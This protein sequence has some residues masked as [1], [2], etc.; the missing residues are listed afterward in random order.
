MTRI[1]YPISL[2]KNPEFQTENRCLLQSRPGGPVHPVLARDRLQRDQRGRRPKLQLRGGVHRGHA[3]ALGPVHGVLQGGAP[4][5][6][7][8]SQRLGEK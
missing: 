5:Q 8:M 2:S 4:G 3:L 6:G 7:W 1:W